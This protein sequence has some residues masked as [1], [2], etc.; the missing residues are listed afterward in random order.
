[1]FLIW[2]IY[3]IK[4]IIEVLGYLQLL[5]HNTGKPQP[6]QMGIALLV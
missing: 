5:T 2:Y 3:D 1:M 4:N 6:F